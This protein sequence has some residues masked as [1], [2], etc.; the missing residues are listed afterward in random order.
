MSGPAG[1][2]GLQGFVNTNPEAT[3]EEI[4]GSPVNPA[5]TQAWWET[6]EF[7]PQ[8]SAISGYTGIPPS[9][10]PV[11]TDSIGDGSADADSALPAGFLAQSPNSDMT[12]R[13]H[14]APWPKG[15]EQSV[16]PDSVTRQLIQS[17]E[18][19]ASDTGAGRTMFYQNAALQDHWQDFYDVEPG[20]SNVDSN[21]GSQAKTGM[22]P[23]GFASHGR[24]QSL[25]RQNQYGFD[26]VH[27]HRRFAVGSVPG[28]Y[29]WMKPGGRPMVKSLP[30]PARPANGPGP[31]EGQDM[32]W[33]YAASSPV[34]GVLQNAPVEYQPPPQPVLAPS[35]SDSEAPM[36]GGD[37]F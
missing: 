21:I 14:A 27:M 8:D 26:A 3:P 5:H 9:G 32:S 4:Q 36:V 24:E 12:P 15:I 34:G 37:L 31:F 28:N 33:G 19:H 16:Q 1:L 25:A 11:F 23:G 29:M 6:A 35:Y 22:A 10:L 20:Q 13:T 7:S 17:A 18:I 30:G 2:T